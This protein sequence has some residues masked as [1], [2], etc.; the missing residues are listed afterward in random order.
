[1][2]WLKTER[3]VHAETLLVAI[4]ALAGFAA[5]NAVWALVKRT[6][7]PVPQFEAGTPQRETGFLCVVTRDGEKFY[8]GELLNMHLFPEG[9]L[10][11]GHAFS[12]W[13][14]VAAAAVLASSSKRVFRSFP[15][16]DG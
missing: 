1:M 15:P 9:G 6:G 12:L 16:S 3:G 8:V 11:A 5:Q 7:R 2:L 13:G 10:G 14:F 4:G